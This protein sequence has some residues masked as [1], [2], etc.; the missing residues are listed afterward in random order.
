[1][2][3]TERAREI[4]LVAAEATAARLQFQQDMADRGFAV[5][6]A[7]GVL[8]HGRVRAVPNLRHNGR[9]VSG[10]FVPSGP[11]PEVLYEAYESHRRQRFTIAH[12][13]GH[14]YLDPYRL[15]ECPP[16]SIDG[17]GPGSEARDL[18]ESEADAFAGAFLLPADSLSADLERFGCCSSFLA[19]LYDVSEPAIRRRIDEL[20]GA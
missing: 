8:I 14:F 17:F 13:L 19:D 5:G 1:M 16:E 12:E 18:R 9:R 7:V 2:I 3:S 10:L 15:P 11:F 6:A 20:K 4:E